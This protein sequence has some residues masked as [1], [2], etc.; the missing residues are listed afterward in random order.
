MADITVPKGNYGYNLAFTIQDADE[1]AY[2]LS[3]YTVTLKVWPQDIMTAPIVNSACT[4]DTAASGTCHY[5]VQNGDFDYIGNYLCELELTQ[6]GIVE[7]TRNYT[8]T[9]EESA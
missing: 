4:I 8:L 1:S 6:S 5:T 7:S 2:N 9:V 3:G